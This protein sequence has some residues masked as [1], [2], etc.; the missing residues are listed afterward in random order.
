[1]AKLDIRKDFVDGMHEVFSTLFN[2]GKED[3]V[4]LYLMSEETHAKDPYGENK[5]KVYQEPKLLI[6][7]AVLNPLQGEQYVLG[8]DIDAE[9][10]VPLKSLTDNGFEMTQAVIDEMQRG[11]MKF[12]DVYYKVDDIKP[13]SYVEDVFLFYAFNCTELKDFEMLL[14]KSKDEEDIPVEEP[15]EDNTTEEVTEDVGFKSNPYR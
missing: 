13:K 4:Y 5:Y 6:C 7:K 11:V 3:G 12:H 2:E 10:T 1:M 15:K 14:E 9:F 8:I